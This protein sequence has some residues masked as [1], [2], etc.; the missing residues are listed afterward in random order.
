MPVGTVVTERR[1]LRQRDS[2]AGR[3]VHE[4][5]HRTIE[6]RHRLQEPDSRARVADVDIEPR[7]HGVAVVG[8]LDVAIV[9]ENDEELILQIWNDLSTRDRATRAGPAPAP[10]E[11][12]H[13]TR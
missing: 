4:E 11:P 7:A 1:I 10:R 5:R 6:D 2:V 8:H 13:V 9:M 12:V 3:A